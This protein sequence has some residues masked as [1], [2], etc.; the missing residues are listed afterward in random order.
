MLGLVLGA[1]LG[2]AG[3]WV[4]Y[5]V[6]VARPGTSAAVQQ[7]FPALHRLFVNK[8]YFDEAIDLLV[9][10]PAAWFGRWGQQTF[11]RVFVNG[12][13]IGATSGL[14]R[15]GSAAVRAAQTGFLRAY[16]A[17]LLLGVVG[18]GLY[19]LIQSA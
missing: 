17:L 15:A 11:E 6:W 3:I 1:A 14:V 8:W 5:Q 12:T 10:R 18:V 9:V 13:L 7:R 19:F 2:L 16:A 4:A